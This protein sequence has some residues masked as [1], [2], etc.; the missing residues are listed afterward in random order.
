MTTYGDLSNVPVGTRLRVLEDMPFEHMKEGTHHKVVIPKN[1]VATVVENHMLDDRELLVLKPE[2]A[3]LEAELLNGTFN[4]GPD[5]MA[6]AGLAE[7]APVD[8]I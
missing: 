3:E 5:G 8:M 2:A 4:I 1:A 6:E 7:T